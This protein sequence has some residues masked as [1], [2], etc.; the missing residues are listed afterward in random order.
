VSQAALVVATARAQT[1]DDPRWQSS[2]LFALS[3]WVK[4]PRTAQRRLSTEFT[5]DQS[6]EIFEESIW[7][8]RSR[9]PHPKF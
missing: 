2:V 6:T 5:L 3:L 8:F 4:P 1:S 7:P 9:L